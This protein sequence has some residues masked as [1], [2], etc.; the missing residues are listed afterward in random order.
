MPLHVNDE[1]LLQ[2]NSNSLGNIIERPRSEFTMLS[3]TIYAIEISA[4]VREST[5]LRNGLQR[6]P[7]KAVINGAKMRQL[8]MNKY[9]SFLANLPSHFRLGNSLGLNST[10]PLA[11]IPVQRWMLH[12]Q[13]WSLFLRL[14][15]AGLYSNDGRASSQLL[16]QNIISSHAQVQSRCTVCGSLSIGDVQLFN[17]A[18]VLLIEL[19]FSST[20]NDADSSAA[21]LH[22]LMTRDKLREAV[23]LL[24]AR[25]EI[26]ESQSLDIHSPYQSKFSA[27][28]GVIALEALMK[29][30]EDLS[31]TPADVHK[32]GNTVEVSSV[33]S[34]MSLKTRVMEI[35]GDLSE[36]SDTWANDDF[37]MSTSRSPEITTLSASSGLARNLDVLPVLSNDPE[38]N[39]WQFMDFTCGESSSEGDFLATTEW[40]PFI[41]SIFTEQL[42]EENFASA[43]GHSLTETWNDA[44]TD[45]LALP[46]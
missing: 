12:Q 31:A 16:A 27:Q 1:D 7:K 25:G 38:C 9:E 33:Q 6:E 28:K 42:P 43:T 4:L 37:D 19:L 2:D 15:R 17:A 46:I 36:R 21:Q 18:A 23:E 44:P 35:L 45:A 5:D 24:R 3:Y 26:I 40:Q 14:H 41:N 32:Q 8:L 39:F 11:A 30:E 20:S 13:L 10:G 22:R 34:R 29:L